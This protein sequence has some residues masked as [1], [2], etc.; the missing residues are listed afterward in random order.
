MFAKSADAI[1]AVHQITR[2]SDGRV[3][4][5]DKSAVDAIMVVYQILQSFCGWVRVA[6]KSVM[7]AINRPL[8]SLRECGATARLDF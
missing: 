1:M 8:R 2:L 6:D 7:G 5:I 4:E 3:R